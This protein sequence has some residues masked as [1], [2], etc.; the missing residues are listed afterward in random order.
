MMRRIIGLV[1]AGLGTFLIVVAIA[2]PT[3]VVGQILKFP[4]NEFETAIFTGSNV[5][6]FSLA[7]LTEETG[8]T[9]R[10]SYTIK[11]DASLGNGSTA[12]W[13]EVE[14][15]YDETND[16]E[17]GLT[18]Q[19]AAFN[20]KTAQLVNCCGANINGNSTIRQ[21]GIVGWVF[22]FNTQKQTY[23]IFDTTLDKPMPYK[24]SGT[25]TVDGVATYKYIENVPPTQFTTLSVPGYFVGSSAKTVSAPEMYSRYV[26]Y[27]VDPETGALV[28]VN[29]YEELALANPTTGVTGLILSKGDLTMEPSSVQSVINL[30]N[31]GRNELFLL[32]VLLPIV[33]GVVGLILLIV[34]IWLGRRRRRGDDAEAVEAPLA[35][36]AAPL[37]ANEAAATTD[38]NLDGHAETAVLTPDEQPAEASAEA[39]AA[40]EAAAP[41]E[42]PAPADES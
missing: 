6:Y 38:P 11:G 36:P 42:A 33:L 20:R 41:E 3:F 23:M 37:A 34:G 4:L 35:S 2:L 21:S 7:Y 15:A 10:A 26:I 40:A 14:Y 8:V 28:D 22:P 18:T 16:Q 9:E 30:D 39:P 32:R 31:S 29:N 1:L 19:R 17:I 27:Y 24:Y 12:V 13:N 25:A 5:S